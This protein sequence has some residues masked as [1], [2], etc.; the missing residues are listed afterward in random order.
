MMTAGRLREKSNQ[1]CTLVKSA[2]ILGLVVGVSP[3][4]IAQDSDD[5]GATV[6]D[7]TPQAQNKHSC[8]I[9]VQR[10]GMLRQSADASVLS[11]KEPGAYPGQAAVTATNGSYRLSIDRPTGF[12]ASPAGALDSAIFD[13][14][15]SGSGASNFFAAPA[16]SDQKIKKGTTNIRVDFT[17]RKLSGSFPSGQYQSQVTLRCE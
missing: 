3:V 13:A 4:A 11:S 12:T 5:S 16:G 7:F 1:M 2:L 10:G 14:E 17:A 8:T 6:N 15:F 9:I